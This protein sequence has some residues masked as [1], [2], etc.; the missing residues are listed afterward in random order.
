MR[1]DKKLVELGLVDTR[2]RA[3]LLI[4]RGAVKVNGLVVA[5]ASQEILENDLVEVQNAALKYV[6]IGGEKLEIAICQFNIMFDGCRVLD[7]GA[8]TGGFTDCAL[9][10]GAK[11]VYAVDVGS[12][13][14][15]VKLKVDKRVKS[16]E[17]KDVRDLTLDEIDGSPVDILVAD[18]SFISLYKVL[19][20]FKE[21]LKPGGKLIALVKPQFEQTEKHRTKGGIIKNERL[22]DEALDRVTESL[23]M[24]GFKFMNSC[25]TDADGKTKNIEYL[26]L[27]KSIGS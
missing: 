4:E 19:P 17:N 6:S 8:S 9:Q 10:H 25:P 2:N 7:A 5:K 20:K 11:L 22:R 23:E 14:L 15:D 1:L 16:L 24:N 18:L 12:D 3:Q 13:Q 26:V 21:L 27:A